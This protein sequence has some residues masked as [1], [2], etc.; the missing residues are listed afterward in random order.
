MVYIDLILNLVRPNFIL[1]WSF[2]LTTI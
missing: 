2:Q 1:T